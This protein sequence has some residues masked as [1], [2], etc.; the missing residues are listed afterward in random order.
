MELD[1]TSSNSFYVKPIR[2]A[3]TVATNQGWHNLIYNSTTGEIA[4]GTLISI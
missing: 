2:N 3:G 1:S 4:F